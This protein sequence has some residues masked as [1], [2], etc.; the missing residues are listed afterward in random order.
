[1][2]RKRRTNHLTPDIQR[3]TPR[4]VLLEGGGMTVE[5]YE[6]DLDRLWLHLCQLIRL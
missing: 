2:I 3:P 4:A 6:E 1:M 5:D